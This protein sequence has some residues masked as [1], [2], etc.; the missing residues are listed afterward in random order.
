MDTVVLVLM[1][2]TAF[3]FLLKQ[4]FWKLIAVGIIAAICAV[5]AGLMW[6]YAIQM[7]YAMLA[8]HVANDYPVKPRMILMYRFLRWFPGLLIFPVLFSGLVYLIFAFPGTS[9]QTIAWSYAAFI[10]AAIP[11]GRFI[12][13]HLLPEKELRLELFFLTNALV[14]V[15]GIVA[16]VNGKTSAAGVSEIDWKALTGVI[17]IALAGGILGLLWWNIR[18]RNKEKSVKQ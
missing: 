10:L 16:T 13:L 17:V 5:F 15:L 2:L 4:T 7:A 6:P 3:N 8:V 14:A 18:N 9:F 11:C 12:L 1:L